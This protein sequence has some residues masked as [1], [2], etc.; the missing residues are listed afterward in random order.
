VFATAESSVT[1]E[2]AAGSSKLKTFRETRMSQ[3]RQS[4]SP[5][6][7]A[8][9]VLRFARERLGPACEMMLA[10]AS[11]QTILQSRWKSGDDLEDATL[12]EVHRVAKQDR[13]VA[14]EFL[15]YFLCDLLNLGHQ[16]VSPGL[17]RFLDTGDLAQSVMGDL[18]S[19]LCDTRF[20]NRA[21][22]LKL[23][24]RMLRNK[25]I[26]KDRE[27]RA[28]R[29]REDLREDR[30][31]EELP[32]ASAKTSPH[33]ALI[34]NE[35]KEHMILVLLRLPERDRQLIQ[36]TLE[37]KSIATLANELKLEKDAARMALN[38]AIQRARRRLSLDETWR[39]EH[40]GLQ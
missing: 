11:V 6:E 7:L 40:S 21:R 36:G 14:D 39:K 27:R 33:G 32:L 15:A 31:P 19:K 37:G 12:R 30:L 26:D 16:F 35:E 18:W 2:A 1:F 13:R 20:E 5:T 34:Q 22:F 29:R 38:R 17:R 10:D 25:A 24:T 3:D 23:I 4:L 28:G 9:E 8:A